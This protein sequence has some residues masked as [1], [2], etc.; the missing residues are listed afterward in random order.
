M[1]AIVL[2]SG[3][4]D[5]TVALYWAIHQGWEVQ[6]L[7]FD[8][9][10]A[11]RMDLHYS[12]II[13]NKA[14]ASQ[15]IIPLTFYDNF[16]VNPQW[17]SSHKTHPAEYYLPVRNAIFYSIAAGY[18]ESTGANIL[19]S[20]SRLE[21]GSHLPDA[22]KEFYRAMNKVLKLGTYTAQVGEPIQIVTPLIDKS[23]KE[24]LQMALALNVPLELTWSCMGSQ[25]PACGKC[26]SCMD[27]LKTFKELNLQDPVMYRQRY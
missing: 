26:S 6:T 8:I 16:Q 19:I 1:K 22:R 2:F 20:G 14:G 13:S 15:S 23:Q 24:T 3:G 9:K 17:I 27:R 12:A 5:S 25:E 10:Q 7:T 11:S 18:A 4:L 21:D